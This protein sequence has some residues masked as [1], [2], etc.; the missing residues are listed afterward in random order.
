M[1]TLLDFR[2]PAASIY[3]IHNIENLLPFSLIPQKP[4]CVILS[5]HLNEL[6]I[7]KKQSVPSKFDSSWTYCHIPVLS[8]T[9]SKHTVQKKQKGQSLFYLCRLKKIRLITNTA[10]KSLAH[11]FL[12][13]VLWYTFP[14]P[15]N[16]FFIRL[17]TAAQMRTRCDFI[18]TVH[19]Q[20]ENLVFFYSPSCCCKMI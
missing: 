10:L 2:S 9:L 6:T 5:L 17:Q 4:C 20:N 19:F 13:L 16:A 15:C 14:S 18:G 11:Y 1:E 3:S 12:S 7:S 8:N